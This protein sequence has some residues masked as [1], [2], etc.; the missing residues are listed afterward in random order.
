MT[1]Y[2]PDEQMR[3]TQHNEND[4]VL[5]RY[6][7]SNDFPMER[8]HLTAFW[9]DDRLA[10]YAAADLTKGYWAGKVR[11]VTRQFLYL[12]GAHECFVIFDRVEAT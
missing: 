5:I 2:H 10:T 1:V 11:E 12:R 8:G 4:G 7:Y 9:H 6:V 3:R